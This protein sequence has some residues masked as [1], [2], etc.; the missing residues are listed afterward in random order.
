VVKNKIPIKTI[1]CPIRVSSLG[2]VN[3][4]CRDLVLEI[5]N[6]SFRLTS[7]S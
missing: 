7:L 4:D 2:I 1:G 6:I 3:A 5:E